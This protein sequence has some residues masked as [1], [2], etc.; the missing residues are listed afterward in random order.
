MKEKANKTPSRRALLHMGAR[1]LAGA[2][3]VG[4]LAQV[5]GA[6][7]KPDDRALVCIYLFGGEGGSHLPNVAELKALHRQGVL[8]VV[9]NVTPSRAALAGTPGEIMKQQYEGLRFLPNGFATLEWAARSAG[10]NPLTGAGA[11]TFKSGM[12][13]VSCDGREHEGEQFENTALRSAMNDVHPLRTSFPDTTVGRQLKDVARLLQTSGRL[14]LL[15]PVF[16]CTATG[17]TNSAH[18][19]NLLAA[20]YRELGQ[21]IA[22]FYHGTVELGL[23]RK[24]TTYT[25]SEF[26]RARAR[27][28]SRLV[29]GGAAMEDTTLERDTYSDL[30]ARWHGAAA[31]ELKQA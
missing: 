18:Q 30:L 21:A 28:G 16:V 26:S 12:S 4:G 8:T 3:L 17:F 29:L 15:R 10:I 31:S 14:G 25:E 1:S 20:R 24:V 13:L 9:N 5:A 22:A 23:E 2:G 19:A 7:S 27:A 6:N 11:F